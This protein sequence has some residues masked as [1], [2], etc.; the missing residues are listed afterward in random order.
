MTHAGRVAIGA[1]RCTPRQA[2]AAIH[3]EPIGERGG[4]P[5][6]LIVVGMGKLGG[7]E[8]NVS[9]D[10]DLVFVYPEDGETGGPRSVS[11]H[12]FF[13]RARP[14]AHRRARTT[15]PRD[16]YV[17]RVDMR[18]RPYGD[19]GPL[20]TRFAV[21]EQYSSTQGRAWERYAWLKARAAHRRRGTPSST[22]L[23]APF[24]YRKYLDYDAYAACATCIA[25]SASRVGA[26]TTRAT[27]SSAP[28]GIR[29]IEFIV[30]AFQLVRGG[31]EP[32]LRVRGT[33]RGARAARASAAC[34]R[35][36]ASA[37][38]ATPTCSCATSSTGCNIATTSRRTTL[39]DDADDAT[40]A[41]RSDG[42]ATG[43]RFDARRSRATATS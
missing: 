16:G 12:E 17:F 7:G 6:Q 28:G 14:Q 33:L 21:L 35:P 24:V 10:I 8:L 23:V 40:R 5:Q 37:S 19:S 29:E 34:C 20:T 15:S 26:A 3:G 13:D 18:L 42:L 27:S 41:R 31:R 30:Q 11:N 2:L 1:V 32:A 22:P 25:R 43:T 4:T 38:C 9:S 36:R 39:P